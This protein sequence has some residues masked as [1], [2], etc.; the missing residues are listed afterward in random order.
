[1]ELQD[2]KVAD[3]L[4]QAAVASATRAAGGGAVIDVTTRS[5][6]PAG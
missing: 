5:R 4:N 2:V 1:M 6:C 3:A